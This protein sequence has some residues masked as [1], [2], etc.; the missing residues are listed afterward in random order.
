MEVIPQRVFTYGDGIPAV[1]SGEWAGIR[2]SRWKGS[3]L[4]LKPIKRNKVS[5]FERMIITQE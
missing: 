3:K 1:K 5:A 4:I 2:P